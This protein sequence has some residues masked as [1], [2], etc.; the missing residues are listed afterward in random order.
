MY[1]MGRLVFVCG[2]DEVLDYLRLANNL[3]R[4]TRHGLVRTEGDER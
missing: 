1:M 4:A 2:R 3:R